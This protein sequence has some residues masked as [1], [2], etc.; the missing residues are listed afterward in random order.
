[1]YG[2]DS[3]NRDMMMSCSDM[4]RWFSQPCNSTTRNQPSVPDME[5]IN[6]AII[7][8]QIT[9]TQRYSLVYTN[10]V[11]D[12]EDISF[13]VIIKQITLTQRYSLVYI[14]LVLDIEGINF[15]IIIK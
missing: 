12:M 1:M 15:A 4:G 2:K 11:L 14:N 6:S 9:L 3:S 10:S 8:K 13:A 7:I 5:G